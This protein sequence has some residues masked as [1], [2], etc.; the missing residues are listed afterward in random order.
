MRAAIEDVTTARSI[1]DSAPDVMV[2][3][4]LQRAGNLLA[5]MDY[6][7][8]SRRVLRTHPD[9]Q[10]ESGTRRLPTAHVKTHVIHYLAMDCSL[11]GW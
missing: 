11:C 7:S 10:F 4:P 2:K 6:H 9:M 1:L 8:V 5:H 3:Q